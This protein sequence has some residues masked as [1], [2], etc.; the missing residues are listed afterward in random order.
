[1]EV[2]D[3]KVSDGEM[4]QPLVEE[5]SKKGRVV[6]AIGDGGYDTKANFHYLA[7]TG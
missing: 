2:T 1:M 7:R 3:E 6:K 5:A 4:L